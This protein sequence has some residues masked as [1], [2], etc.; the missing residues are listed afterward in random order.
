MSTILFILLA[1]MI[2]CALGRTAE[3]QGRRR[4]P[5]SGHVVVDIVGLVAAGCRELIRLNEARGLS[6]YQREPTTWPS[7]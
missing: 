3:H 1:A 6:E 7:A 4:R 2:F 5:A